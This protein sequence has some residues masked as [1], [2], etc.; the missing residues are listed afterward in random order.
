M[1][2][3]IQRRAGSIVEVLRHRAHHQGEQLAYAFLRDGEALEEP[4]TYGLLDRR[5]RTLAAMLLERARPGEPVLIVLQPGLGYIA[6][7]FACFYARL[8]AVPSFPPRAR[9]LAGTLSAISR[10][11]HPAVMLTD[12]SSEPGVAAQF[13][14]DP[15]F[16]QVPRL[17]VGPDSWT[18]EI[19]V[20]GAS[21][22]PAD[23]ALLQYTSGSTGNPKGVMV[24]HGNL[25]DNLEAAVRRFGI[26]ASSRGV[27]WLPPY[28]DMGLVA[29]TLQPVY[30]ACVTTI[31]SP[32]HA[33][34]RPIRWLK[35]IQRTGATI[36]GGP[37][38]GYDH[39][40]ATIDEP[41]RHELDLT[42]WDCAFVGA[43]PVRFDVLERFAGAFG[44]CGFQRRSFVPCYGL[45]EATLMVTGRAKG[46]GALRDSTSGH[47]ELG[48]T[49]CGQVID[50]H[51]LLIV[52]PEHRIPCADGKEGEIWIEG[53]SVAIGY[54][55]RPA[56]TAAAFGAHLADGRGPYLR[57]GDLG[58]MI[59]GELTVTGRVKD[60]VIVAGRKLHAEDIEA[61]IHEMADD[62]LRHGSN[63]VFAAEIGGK[64]RIIVAVELNRAPGRM[65]GDLAPI[66]AAIGA[67]VART[68]DVTVHDVAFL[69]PGEIPR[70]SSGKVRRH[71]CRA[72]YL[73]RQE[74]GA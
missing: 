74:K 35:A 49:T 55:N 50:G 17:V 42:S 38:F 63:A 33:M 68:H 14:T 12:A 9:R 18:S 10:D 16:A 70:T 59:D 19:A 57:T 61:T 25:I 41:L 30:S 43:E 13:A 4:M 45:A 54:W 62:R 51:E 53:P 60:L 31:L 46:G 3:N 24:S 8:V 48:R 29:G 34:Q 39:C 69:A 21:P 65:S 56:E 23:L 20:D 32:M 64:E 5:A 47:E 27:T 58:V 1:S 7:L 40:V 71:L 6:A 73:D 67:A 2:S 37:P 36:S 44:P 22:D 66:R 52:E 72:Q 28:H 26:G 15:T 11:C